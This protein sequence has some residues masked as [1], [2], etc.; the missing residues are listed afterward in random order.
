M[1]RALSKTCDLLLRKKCVLV[2]HLAVVQLSVHMHEVVCDFLSSVVP[3]GRKTVSLE[4]TFCLYD[5]SL[6]SKK[7]NVTT[8]RTRMITY[9]PL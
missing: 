7:G 1:H 8:L 9:L 3:G 2:G 4:V 6:G 5:D